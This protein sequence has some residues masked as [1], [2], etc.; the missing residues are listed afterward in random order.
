MGR[1]K[2]G[3]ISRVR[4]LAAVVELTEML[5]SVRELSQRMEAADQKVAA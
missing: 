5:K 4:T 1:V 3:L 2:L